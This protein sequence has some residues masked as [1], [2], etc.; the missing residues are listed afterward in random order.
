MQSKEFEGHINSHKIVKKRK[1]WY[2][3]Y[4]NFFNKIAKNR[5]KGR[6]KMMDV[7]CLRKEENERGV[8]VI[9][10]PLKVNIF[11]GVGIDDPRIVVEDSRR[12]TEQKGESFV[13]S[14][15]RSFE[16]KRDCLHLNSGCN[17]RRKGT[18][19]IID[20]ID[21]IEMD[22]SIEELIPGVYFLP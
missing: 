3:R 5:Q 20:G 22:E 9:H 21:E 8:Q 19:L 4:V 14:K 12:W 10:G 11:N 1:M 17:F 16:I 13:L 2:N 7:V 15:A 18:L 6:C